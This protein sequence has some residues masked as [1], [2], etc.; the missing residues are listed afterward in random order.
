[1]I[2]IIAIVGLFLVGGIDVQFRALGLFGSGVVDLP[3]EELAV[4]CL[5]LEVGDG[6][7]E[8]EKGD[9]LERG[10]HGH[11][12]GGSCD[13]EGGKGHGSSYIEEV[14]VWIALLLVRMA[15]REAKKKQACRTMLLNLLPNLSF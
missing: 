4:S 15:E 3:I 14:V 7:D 13:D 1:M 10:S 6:G 2:S 8:E 5:S 11:Y 9:E 12:L